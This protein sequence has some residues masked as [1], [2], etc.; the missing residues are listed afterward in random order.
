VADK[1]SIQNKNQL[2]DLGISWVEM[3]SKNGFMRFKLALEKLQIPH[4]HLDKN[5][6]QN[7]DEIFEE[8]F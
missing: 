3:R 6:E 5:F 2:D 8:I 7:L 4:K 1:L